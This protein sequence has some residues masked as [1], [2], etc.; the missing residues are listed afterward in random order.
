M[1]NARKRQ[2][3]EEGKNAIF[4]ISGRKLTCRENN[5]KKQ[6]KV[7]NFVENAQK[8]NRLNSLTISIPIFIIYI[9]INVGFY[10]LAKIDGGFGRCPNA[11]LS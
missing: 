6:K 8:N 11:F 5:A 10:T 7:K 1:F 4:S 2:K 3:K 9:P